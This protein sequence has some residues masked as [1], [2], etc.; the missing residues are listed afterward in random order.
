MRRISRLFTLSEEAGLAFATMLCWACS[1][2]TNSTPTNGCP[3]CQCPS[4]PYEWPVGPSTTSP[5]T[6]RV[7][8]HPEQGVIFRSDSYSLEYLMPVTLTNTGLSRLVVGYSWLFPHFDVQAWTRDGQ[9]MQTP[10]R[11]GK[12]AMRIAPGYAEY[13]VLNPTESIT[14]RVPLC[15]L[16]NRQ[17][18]YLVRVTYDGSR[19]ADVR[20]I[21][22]T[23]LY[24]R[25][26]GRVTSDTVTVKVFNQPGTSPRPH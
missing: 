25:F 1:S 19:G 2:T 14:L 5:D 20:Y 8:P 13:V 17:G 7:T 3:Q 10:C 21:G 9:P 23:R 4:A 6:L 26:V 15:L 24:L 18:E 12:R 22:D 16:N 11:E